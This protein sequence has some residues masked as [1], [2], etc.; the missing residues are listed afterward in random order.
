MRGALL[1]LVPAGQ[2]V[3]TDGLR[4]Y[5]HLAATDGADLATRYG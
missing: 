1:D 4:A 5:Y 2:W 3:T